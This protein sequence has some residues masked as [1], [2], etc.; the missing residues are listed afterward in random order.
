MVTCGVLGGHGGEDPLPEPAGVHQH[1]VLVH[2]GDLVAAPGG[3]LEGVPDDA[4]DAVR[5]VD[6][7]LGGDLGGGAGADDAAV[8]DVQALGALADDDEVDL[9]LA[10]H[11]RGQGSDRA[12]EQ[13]A[14]PQVHVVVEGEAQLEQQTP[15]EQPAGHVGG[16]GRRADG[17]EQDGVGLGQLGQHGVR[18]HLTG[19][20]PVARA[21][22]VVRGGDHALTD[23]RVEDLEALGDDLGTDAV[24]A[25]HGELD[26][27]GTRRCGHRRIVTTPCQQVRAISGG[28]L[29]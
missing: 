7:D 16:A 11:R 24:T 5:G 28:A 4:L 9:A 25:D 15:L 27:S 17:A 22:V 23:H 19:A 2:Q 21:Q 3:P 14:G 10:G 26:G 29:A 13:P 12:G 8:A 1:V 18:Q 20:L 6:A